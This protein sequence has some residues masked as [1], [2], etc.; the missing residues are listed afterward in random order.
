MNGWA[1]NFDKHNKTADFFNS[2][3]RVYKTIYD[4]VETTVYLTSAGD[5]ERIGN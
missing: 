1:I 3:K 4:Q 5:S 2:N